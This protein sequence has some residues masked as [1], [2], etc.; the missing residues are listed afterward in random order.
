MNMDRKEF[1]EQWKRIAPSTL[2]IVTIKGGSSVYADGFR[3]WG[4]RIVDLYY[5]NNSIASILL[6][7]IVGVA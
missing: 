4:R 6:E 3:F 5:K 2:R 1:E 7:D